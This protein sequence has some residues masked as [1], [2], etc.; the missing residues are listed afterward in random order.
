MSDLES[1]PGCFL[2]YPRSIE[3]NSCKNCSVRRLCE[4]ASR[5]VKMRFVPKALLEEVDRRLERCLR[6]IHGD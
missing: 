1:L 2:E 5:R 4:V 3:P 6:I